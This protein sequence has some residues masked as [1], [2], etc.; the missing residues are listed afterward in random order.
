MDTMQT[1][2]CLGSQKTSRGDTRD[3]RTLVFFFS[4]SYLPSSFNCAFIFTK[5]KNTYLSVNL[6]TNNLHMMSFF[7]NV[8]K[9]THQSV[10]LKGFQKVR[11]RWPITKH[12]TNSILRTNN[13]TDG[14]KTTT[15]TT[16]EYRENI[17]TKT[18]RTTHKIERLVV[19]RCCGKTIERTRILAISRQKPG[20][21][22]YQL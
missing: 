12:F 2:V 4:V 13:Y 7:G 18:N 21:I 10:A 15:T 11:F 16:T 19:A 20:R 5:K 8:K 17:V 14:K 6:L 9:T 22:E 1:S 3:E